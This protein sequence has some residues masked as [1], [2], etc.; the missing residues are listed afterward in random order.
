M[1]SSSYV[2]DLYIFCVLFL[3]LG[4]MWFHASL[5]QWGG[6]IDAASMYVFLAFLVFYSIRG[7]SFSMSHESVV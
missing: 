1:K 6:V 4:S 5:T 3:G 2:P 7:Y